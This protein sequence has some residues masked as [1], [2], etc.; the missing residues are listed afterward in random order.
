MSVTR[1]LAGLGIATIFAATSASAVEVWF[2]DYE[3]PATPDYA[4]FN[5]LFLDGVK[6]GLIAYSSAIEYDGGKPRFCLPGNLALT[7]EQAEDIM[8]RAA[9]K[10]K[11]S[12]NLPIS[13]LLLIGLEETFPCNK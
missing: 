5:K 8:R 6:S 2:K 9:K 7:V 11:N 1:I 4:G 12:D 3:H 10:H 13:L